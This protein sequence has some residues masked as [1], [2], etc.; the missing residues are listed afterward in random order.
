MSS[1][2]CNL[3][4]SIRYTAPCRVENFLRARVEKEE[5]F[6]AAV[7]GSRSPPLQRGEILA[8]SAEIVWLDRYMLQV[9]FPGQH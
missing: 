6:E 9:V 3:H 4:T 2:S 5:S 1:G 8:M 7:Q